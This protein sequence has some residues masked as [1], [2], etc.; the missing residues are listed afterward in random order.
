MCIALS[1]VAWLVSGMMGRGKGASPDLCEP[2]GG[3]DKSFGLP[4]EDVSRARSKMEYVI[5]EEYWALQ[6]VVEGIGPD[7][8][9]ELWN[10]EFCRVAC[11]V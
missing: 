9:S 8:A 7:G 2:C 5:M 6:C 3:V 4:I 11:K 10:I 1:V